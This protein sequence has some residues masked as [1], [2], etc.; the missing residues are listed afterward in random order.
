M[1]A[2][3]EDAYLEHNARLN[4]HEHDGWRWDCECGASG[5]AEDEDAALAAAKFHEWR[6][7]LA[8]ALS[9]GGEVRQEWAAKIWRDD[10][11]PERDPYFDGRSSRA[12]ARMVVN[13]HAGHRA[14]SPHW[15]GQAV[16]VQRTV[17]ATP[18]REVPQ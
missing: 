10:D 6:A 3:A 16:L 11:P 1:A 12:A 7:I 18:W 9:V 17:L 5:D 8:A 4:Q 13:S 15:R 14:S 2:A